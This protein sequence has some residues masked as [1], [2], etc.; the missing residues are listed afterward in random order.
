MNKDIIIAIDA[1]TSVLKA[2]A[3][4]LKGNELATTSIANIYKPTA[5]KTT[6]KIEGNLDQIVSRLV[7]VLKTE[8]KVL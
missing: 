1:G 8:I 6:V 3:F 2:V 4:S 5:E 7:D